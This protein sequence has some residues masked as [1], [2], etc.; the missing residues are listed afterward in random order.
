MDRSSGSGVFA[1]DPDAILDLVEL[2]ITEGLMRQQQDEAVCKVYEKWFREK[3]FN[4][5]DEYIGR[6]DLLSITSL[7]DHSKR[8]L[9]DYQQEIAIE[10]LQAAEDVKLRTAWRIEGT[11]R[12]FP[13]F[14]ARNMWFEFPVHKLDDS[15]LLKKA[16][17]EGDAP[18][19]QKATKGKKE[20]NGDRK[21][22]RLEALEESFESVSK[23]GKV[24]IKELS[25][26]VGKA[27]RTV[28]NYVK[29]HPDFDIQD[30]LVTEKK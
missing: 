29:E 15:G 14:D 10:T 12:E 27:E 24:T 21:Q 30:G 20:K 25:E 8:A 1:R 18:P 2:E 11:L 28:R 23:D 7:L 19:W 4:Y 6:D 9:K 16:N 13:K 3:N 17:P 5:F 26:A 22:E